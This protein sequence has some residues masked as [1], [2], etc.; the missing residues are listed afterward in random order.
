MS[1]IDFCSDPLSI[2]TIYPEE[3]VLKCTSELDNKVSAI[4]FYVTP[5]IYAFNACVGTVLSCTISAA[6][7]I[8]TIPLIL[9]S[10]AV[11]WLS[12]NALWD[13]KSECPPKLIPLPPKEPTPIEVPSKGDSRVDVWKK[14]SAS[15]NQE[16][17]EK[18][19]NSYV[20][21]MTLNTLVD[22][23]EDTQ[24]KFKE[25]AFQVPK[26]KVWSQKLVDE[27]NGLNYQQLTRQFSL[28][29]LTKYAL[30]TPE[31]F[32]DSFSTFAR[33]TTLSASL[34]EYEKVQPQLK[35][36]PT[37]SLSSLPVWKEK[38]AVETSLLKGSEILLS[39][40]LQSLKEV[41]AL[42]E[43][44]YEVLKEV[45]GLK[46]NYQQLKESCKNEI[47]DNISAAREQA[48]QTANKIPEPFLEQQKTLFDHYLKD[49]Q[50]AEAAA[51]KEMDA[52]KNR[53]SSYKKAHPQMSEK[54][55]AHFL[56][57]EKKCADACAKIQKNFE[58][59]KEKEKK[60]VDSAQEKLK[61]ALS[62]AN[63][64]KE[65]AYALAEKEW[66]ASMNDLPK[67]LDAQTAAARIETE[68]KISELNTEFDRLRASH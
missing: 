16:E 65:E 20:E 23:Y 41:G 17:F 42:T 26:P 37:Y 46:N 7:W 60:K 28:I 40:P 3:K 38:F 35:K 55:K 4:W 18:I 43:S 15:A 68:K 32:R 51:Q 61:E 12:V 52:E 58:A 39:Y 34:E 9:A 59:K 14:L 64:L 6:L 45:D 11:F 1:A 19:Y 50:A 2:D 29:R 53:L 44:Q 8:P 31:Q 56:H 24:G 25:T 62:K 67:L 30:L 48:L 47:K 27:T 63:L 33:G 57:L 21:T 36:Y 10:G 54:E 49:I 66:T 22:F 13:R 5:V